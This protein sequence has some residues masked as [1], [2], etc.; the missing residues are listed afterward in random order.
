M[1]NRQVR[2][3]AGTAPDPLSKSD[4]SS[5]LVARYLYQ[6]IH[7]CG[8][9]SCKQLTC[10]SR[11]VP[12]ALPSSS[13]DRS[14]PLFAGKIFTPFTAL[15]LAIHLASLRGSNAL[16]YELRALTLPP[17]ILQ[18]INEAEPLRSA[19]FLHAV[20]QSQHYNNNNKPVKTASHREANKTQRST[21]PLSGTHSRGAR[22]TVKKKPVN[23]DVIPE[24][25]EQL[26]ASKL[27]IDSRIPSIPRKTAAANKTSPV[28]K[29]AAPKFAIP[30]PVIAYNFNLDPNIAF[31]WISGN[32]E[33]DEV[34]RTNSLPF[35]F[36]TQKTSVNSVL[37]AGMDPKGTKTATSVISILCNEALWKPRAGA[38]T[39]AV[40]LFPQIIQF[41]SY[42]TKTLDVNNQLFFVRVA[43][44]A[45]F[46]LPTLYPFIGEAKSMLKI[47][48]DEKVLL[49]CIDVIVKHAHPSN[50]PYINTPVLFS[51]IID[52]NTPTTIDYNK[53]V[54]ETALQSLHSFT[55]YLQSPYLGLIFRAHYGENPI[56]PFAKPLLVNKSI[57]IPPNKLA[58]S[59]LVFFM[60]TGTPK[61]V[62]KYNGREKLNISQNSQPAVSLS[63]SNSLVPHS[64]LKYAT[65]MSFEQRYNIFRYRMYMRMRAT[66]ACTMVTMAASIELRAQL[67]YLTT[68]MAM[69]VDRNCIIE[70]AFEELYKAHVSGVPHVVRQPLRV[71]FRGGGEIAVDQGGV[72]VEFFRC[73]SEELMDPKHGFFEVDEESKL[74]WFPK[75]THRT[76]AEYFRVGVMFGIAIYNG[77]TLSVSMP[78]IFYHFILDSAEYKCT[79]DIHSILTFCLKG[80]LREL[81]PAVYRSFDAMVQNPNSIEAMCIPDPN[82]HGGEYLTRATF[83]RYIEDWMNDRILL[84]GHTEMDSMLKGIS[85]VLELPDI[86]GFSLEEVRVLFEGTR[87]PT[88]AD[89]KRNATYD[90]GFTPKSPVVQQFWDI[91]ETQFSDKDL[92]R[93]LE[94]V[95]G[96]D[97]MPA[98]KAFDFVIQKNGNERDRIPAAS[99]CFSR[100]MLPEYKSKR[101][102]EKML[103]LALENVTGFGLV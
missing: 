4:S 81:Y 44:D 21:Q 83:E 60:E 47:T 20:S 52:P 91:V 82:P 98:S 19:V 35:D 84:W 64:A 22:H 5:K 12:L 96:S 57:A 32:S 45:I 93:L 10:K 48:K 39:L 25:P 28:S 33:N 1:T 51:S 76:D 55:P 85:L 101:H 50:A 61:L 53:A 8:S 11:A 38:S 92:A 2:H 7:G 63:S 68:C 23:L 80:Y 65:W 75:T 3:F 13:R 9:K 67:P 103:R 79:G 78:L 34:L 18:N 49:E 72:Q 54:I 69:S 71:R 14:H 94:F 42:A 87:S 29:P 15:N 46:A 66:W 62:F 36:L 70:S 40:K 56:I 86:Y 88:A 89:L 26:P 99:V 6:I 58:S 27:L 73:F 90:G 41:V 100:L 102:L 74:A 30:C 16:C 24:A 59:P 95:T 77:C 37:L 31:P 17:H 97:R 43:S